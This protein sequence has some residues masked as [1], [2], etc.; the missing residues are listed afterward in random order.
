MQA[1]NKKAV[2]NMTSWMRNQIANLYNFVLAPMTAT[3]GTFER[4]QS[5][6]ETDFL[7]Y[8]RMV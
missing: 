4:L 7:L 5:V 1:S 3:R 2:T 8:N 6:N